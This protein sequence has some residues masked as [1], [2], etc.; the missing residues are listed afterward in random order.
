MT[1]LAR[2]ILKNSALKAPLMKLLIKLCQMY[3]EAT[4]GNT[5]HHNT[6]VLI[7]IK[8]LFFKYDTNEGR[9]SLFRAIWRMFIGEF[10]HDPYYRNRFEW[11]IDELN[12]RD[13]RRRIRTRPSRDNCWKEPA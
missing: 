9:N 13:W 11:F 5:L 4:K 3:P 8:D 7:D 10:E 2:E 12:K 6:H 1:G